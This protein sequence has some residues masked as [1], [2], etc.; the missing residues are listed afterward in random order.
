MPPGPNCRQPKWVDGTQIGSK[1]SLQVLYDHVGGPTV[2]KTM[3]KRLIS[4]IK[5]LMPPTSCSQNAWTP[6]R[7]EAKQA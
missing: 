2:R 1:T 5:I 4:E 7:R 6:S 3:L